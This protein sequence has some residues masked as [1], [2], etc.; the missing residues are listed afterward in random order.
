MTPELE[1]HRESGGR[2]YREIL[3]SKVSVNLPLEHLL[4]LT[5]EVV[6]LLSGTNKALKFSY[7]GLN[8]SISS[9]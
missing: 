7:L 8:E 2:C 3:Q 5:L 4:R 9:S 6:E 1:D